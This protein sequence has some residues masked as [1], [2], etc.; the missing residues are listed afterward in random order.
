MEA[1]DVVRDATGQKWPNWRVI[2]YALEIMM[3]AVE[4][5]GGRIPLHREKE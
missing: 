5:N 1:K 2:Q 4:E 3:A